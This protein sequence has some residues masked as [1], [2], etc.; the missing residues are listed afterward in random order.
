MNYSIIIPVY[1]GEKTIPVLVEEIRSFF[2]QNAFS[3]EIVFIYDNGQDKSWKVILEL[4]EKYPT[5][6]KAIKLTRNYGQHNAIICGFEH[7]SGQYFITMDEDLQHSPQD[8][9]L[10]I[11]KQEDTNSDIVYGVYNELNHNT[12]RNIT[13]TI[14]RKVL[15][16]AIEDLHPNYSAFRLLRK[17]IALEST[18]MQNSY[19][20]LDG[21][22]SWITTNVRDT[23]VSHQK[24][25]SGESGYTTKKLFTH[26]ANILFTFSSFPIKL[27][28]YLS[29]IIFSLT[30]V[31][32]S[33]LIILKL[34]HI[35]FIKGFP[36]LIIVTSFGISLILLGLSIIGEYLF[37]INLKTT[38]RPNYLV[39]QIYE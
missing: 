9:Q 32:S 26:L 12:F 7:A 24:R 14:I 27:L 22:L 35:D 37:R 39:E 38:R 11:N 1:N 20:F 4:R 31:Y 5:L 6:V 33:Y 30:V 15:S 25:L 17:E 21:Y 19:T 3:F 2:A 8:I 29:V 34:L 10:L 28:T 16:N 36:T 23:E 18:K 13:S